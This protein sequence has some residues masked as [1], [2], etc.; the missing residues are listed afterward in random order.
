MQDGKI[1]KIFVLPTSALFTQVSDK[2]VLMYVF[3]K[4]SEQVHT[5]H[6]VVDINQM[7]QTLEKEIEMLKLSRRELEQYV[8]RTDMWCEFAGKWRIDI[9][10]SNVSIDRK[11]RCCI[12]YCSFIWYPELKYT[13]VAISKVR[14][15][16]YIKIH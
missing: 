3:I 4:L 13:N 16:K 5:V 7:Q 1:P 11:S 2:N 6:R 14:Y 8:E 10:S 9:C 15:R 12:V